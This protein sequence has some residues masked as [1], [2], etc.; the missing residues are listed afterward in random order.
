MCAPR[1]TLVRTALL[2]AAIYATGGA[3]AAGSGF[4]SS[5]AAGGASLAT[6]AA[7]TTSTLSTLANAA[8]YVLP[9]VSAGGQIFQGY[10][11]ANIM[12]QKANFVS[13]EIASEKSAFALRKAQKR[14]EMIQAIGKQRALYGV[15][16]A[17]LEGSPA[18][19]LGLTAS[20]FAE[21]IFID[22]FNT[23]QKILGKEQ[24]KDI[25][26]SEAQ[27]SI[28]GGYTSAATTLGT[29]GFMDI[30]TSTPSKP[31]IGPNSEISKISRIRTQTEGSS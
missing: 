8:R 11:N 4:L 7:S 6:Q 12:R 23:S 19:V 25:L 30:I 17:T 3:A 28:I 13:Y 18:D 1:S 16:G 14:R 31:N 10:M 29:R 9:V 24:Q 2:G 20:N 21:N 5:G 27:A 26:G 15:T 22:S